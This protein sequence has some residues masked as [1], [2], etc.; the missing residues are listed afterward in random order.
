MRRLRWRRKYCCR[1]WVMIVVVVVMAEG[2]FFIQ[3][4]SPSFP[5]TSINV[6][7]SSFFLL[8]LSFPL[9]LYFQC[10]SCMS[11][12]VFIIS[13]LFIFCF[14]GLLLL[15]FSVLVA[16]F[17]FLVHVCDRL[18]RY[19][20][21]SLYSLPSLSFFVGL[22]SSSDND[23]RI[24]IFFLPPHFLDGVFVVVES[25][26]I[27]VFYLCLSLICLF[28]CVLIPSL[29]AHFKPY[30]HFLCASSFYGLCFCYCWNAYHFLFSTSVFLVCLC[31]CLLIRFIVHLFQP[32]FLCRISWFLYTALILFLIL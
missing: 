17:S 23:C 31:A 11:L 12:T 13:D 10:M 4:V 26:I 14:F 29:F 16:I 7:L 3:I 30:S 19:R 18:Y 6:S 8:I 27:F 24:F 9:R 22:L 21:R 32:L 20:S 5:H 25:V 1:W 28:I 2:F 15:G